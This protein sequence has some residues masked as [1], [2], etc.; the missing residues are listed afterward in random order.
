[1][2]VHSFPLSVHA[3]GVSV[4]VQFN[5]KAAEYTE[6]DCTLFYLENVHFLLV[7]SFQS[8]HNKTFNIEIFEDFK[9]EILFILLIPCCWAKNWNKSENVRERKTFRKKKMKY[10]F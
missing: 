9:V 1:V 8:H 10:G 3:D 2:D 4:S 5:V 7:S 6:S